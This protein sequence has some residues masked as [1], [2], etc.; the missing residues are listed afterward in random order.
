MRKLVAE[1]K[2]FK[3]VLEEYKARELSR[4]EAAAKCGVKTS[5]FSKWA[6][7]AGVKVDCYGVMTYTDKNGEIV[8]VEKPKFEVP[9]GRRQYTEGEIKTK[10]SKTMRDKYHSTGIENSLAEAKK[11]GLSYGKY[12]AM[13]KMGA[14]YQ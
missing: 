12:V 4:K 11:L 8:R 1:R 10:R 6:I 2:K 14:V 3:T 7:E 13:K 9:R 5:T